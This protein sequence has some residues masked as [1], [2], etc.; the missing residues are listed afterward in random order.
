MS[1]P[2]AGRVSIVTGSSRGIGAAV[3]RRLASQ[4][5]N[6]VINYV[7]NAGAAQSVADEINA[8]GAGKAITL[9][10]DM[11]SLA[12]GKRL[13]DDTLQQLGRLD[14][15][16]L[17]AAIMKLNLLA[18]VTE[19]DFDRHYNTNVKGPLFMVQHAVPHLKPGTSPFSR[20]SQTICTAS[21]RF[22]Y[23]R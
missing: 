19:E 10:A 11:T 8:K 5:A 13:I 20:Q 7:S 16:V 3:V 4:G 23:R 15:L 21:T 22:P 12:D 1:L 2:L 17:N 6:V 14:I 18:D 9:K